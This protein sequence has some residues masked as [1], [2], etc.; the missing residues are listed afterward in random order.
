LLETYS[1]PER[2]AWVQAV[3]NSNSVAEALSHRYPH[4]LEAGVLSKLKRVVYKGF[5]VERGQFLPGSDNIH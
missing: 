2:G 5:N 1:T 3:L 4:N